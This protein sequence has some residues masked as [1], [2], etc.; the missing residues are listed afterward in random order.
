MRKRCASVVDCITI[1]N[2]LTGTV[3]DLRSVEHSARQSDEQVLPRRR[4]EF[5]AFRKDIALV[6]P[7]F[8]MTYYDDY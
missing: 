4:D 7:I 1:L 8:H 3:V 6:L 5:C 2:R